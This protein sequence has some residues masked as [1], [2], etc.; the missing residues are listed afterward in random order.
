[1]HYEDSTDTLL[2]FGWHTR[3]VPL[4]GEEVDDEIGLN[5]KVYPKVKGT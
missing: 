2:V 5:E 4:Q 3:K 1:M